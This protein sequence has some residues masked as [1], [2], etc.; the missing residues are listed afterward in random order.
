MGRRAEWK[1]R[2]NVVNVLSQEVI[3]GYS[4]SIPSVRE[5]PELAES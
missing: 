2:S 4:S 1:E 3:N 5:L